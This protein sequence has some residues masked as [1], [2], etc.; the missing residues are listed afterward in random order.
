MHCYQNCLSIATVRYKRLSYTFDFKQRFLCVVWSCLEY[1][2]LKEEVNLMNFMA[3]FNMR[4]VALDTAYW[5][6]LNHLF[7]WGS[8]IVFFPFT[9]GLCSNGF[10]GLLPSSF[11]FVGK[12]IVLKFLLMFH[13]LSHIIKRFT[14]RAVQIKFMAI[15]INLIAFYTK[16]IVYFYLSISS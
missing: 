4:Q 12:I 7:T 13:E 3:L 5:T 11:P 16:V 8:I 14:D 6:G 15:S 1:Q 2:M 9:L 10:F